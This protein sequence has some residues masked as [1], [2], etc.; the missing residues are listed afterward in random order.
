MRTLN[1]IMAALFLL[2]AAVQFNDPDPLQ[3]IAVYSAAAIACIF[4][5][6]GLRQSRAAGVLR[7]FVC[8]TGIAAFLWAAFLLPQA[9]YLQAPLSLS[10]VF[11]PAEMQND[12]VEIVREIGGL[13]IVW[14]WMIV[15]GISIRSS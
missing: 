6:V 4:S 15:L 13:S 5:A 11:G 1:L 14:L 7:A 12:R 9:L 10:S 2:S 8:L 3:W